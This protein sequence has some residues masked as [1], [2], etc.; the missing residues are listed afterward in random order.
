MARSGLTNEQFTELW[1]ASASVEE[2]STKSGIGRASCQTKASV[3]RK[4]GAS[5]KKFQKGRKPKVVPNENV[6]LGSES[7]TVVVPLPVE[8]TTFNGNVDVLLV[9]PK[10]EGEAFNGGVDAA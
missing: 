1:N 4:G 2:V 6:E 5:L 9:S 8:S 7:V 10:P 3:L